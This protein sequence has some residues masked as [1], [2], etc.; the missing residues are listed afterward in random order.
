MATLTTQEV[1]ADGLT[2]S[3][4]AADDGGDEF[5]NSSTAFVH[6]KNDGA[7]SIDATIVS[8]YEAR[9][10]V[11]PEDIV[12]TVAAGEETLAGPFNPRVFD[13]VDGNVEITYSDVTDV[14]VAALS[15]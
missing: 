7:S 11:G 13:N 1:D 9:P 6:I 2:A 8:Q 14:T 3:Y 12:I 10:G 4:D 15:L 5:P